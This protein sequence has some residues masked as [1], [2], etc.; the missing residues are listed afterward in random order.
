MLVWPAIFAIMKKL[1]IHF[2][3]CLCCFNCFESVG[4][5]WIVGLTYASI[6][7]QNLSSSVELGVTGARDSA[8]AIVR[9]LPGT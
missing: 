6:S 8:S 1:L 4:I 2:I 9:C 3:L 5:L 7:V